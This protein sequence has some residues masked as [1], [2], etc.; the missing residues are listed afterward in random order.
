MSVEVVMNAARADVVLNRP[1]VL[2]A[3]DWDTFADL[4]DAADRVAANDEVRVVV[5]RGEGRAFSS[6]IDTTM[7]GRTAGLPSEMVEH[8]QKGFRKLAA[9]D[10]PV[11]AAVHG[12]ALGAG[13]QLALVCDLRIVEESAQLGLLE[14]RYG[15]IP[16]LGGTQRLPLLAGPSTAKKMMWLAE[17]INGREA[18]RTGIADVICDTGSLDQTVDDIA[19]RLAAA[20]PIVVE[21]VKRLV[22]QAA[23]MNFQQAMD[24]VARA[25]QEVLESSDFAEAIAAFAAKRRPVFRGR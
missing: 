21:A 5:V 15:L 3:I 2:N 17:K 22:D 8:A 7:F 12:Y 19:R 13:M 6:G 11:L 9:L 1:D 18:F 20:P 4:A 10:V 25:Q 23:S 16:D 24:S 14:T